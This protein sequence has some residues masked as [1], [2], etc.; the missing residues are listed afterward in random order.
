MSNAC[1]IVL[2]Q[3]SANLKLGRKRSD[4]EIELSAFTDSDALV[5]LTA[6]SR[7]TMIQRALK[8]GAWSTPNIDAASAAIANRRRSRGFPARLSI[9]AAIPAGS[10]GG[11]QTPQPMA[12]TIRVA[13]PSGTA[14]RTGMPIPMHSKIL[15]G[16]TVLKTGASR[17]GTN[18]TAQA[19][20]LRHS[21]LGLTREHDYALKLALRHLASTRALSTPPPTNR[22]TIS[23][24]W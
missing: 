19:P 22:N 21:P 6:P 2:I 5:L 14:M 3:Y 9:A 18:A 13:S 1:N 10:S 8:L 16:I 17:S 24:R 11:T 12:W 7:V 20:D 23:S 4:F 15:D